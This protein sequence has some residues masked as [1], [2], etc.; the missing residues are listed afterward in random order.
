ML[1]QGSR[2]IICSF[3]NSSSSHG[4]FRGR[5]ESEVFASDA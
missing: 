5:D 3:E 4:G 2:L 1:V